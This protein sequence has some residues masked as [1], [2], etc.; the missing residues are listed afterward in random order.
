MFT[1]AGGDYS[2]LSASDHAEFVKGFNNNEETAKKY[3][4]MMAHPPSS[5]TPI[6]R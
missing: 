4:E 3:W 6:G 5:Q 2:K 1:K